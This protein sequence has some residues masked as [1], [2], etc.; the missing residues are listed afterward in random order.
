[1]KARYPG[2]DAGVLTFC[3]LGRRVKIAAMMSANE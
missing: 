1:M 3:A 2:A